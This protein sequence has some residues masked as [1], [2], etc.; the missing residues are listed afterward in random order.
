MALTRLQNI[1]SSVEGRIIYV[2]PD[3][4]DSTDAIDNKG[5]SPLRPFK[6]I[7]RAVLEVARY[8]YVSAGNADDKFDQ[9]TIML[10]PGDH[11]VDNRPGSYA[12]AI[13]GN[14]NYVG[15]LSAVPFSAGPVSGQYGWSD[16]T[17]QYADLYKI[18]NS[19]RG[20]L[21]IP[22][23]VS[24]VGM[25]LRKTK[26]RPKFVP[27][28][29]TND[30]TGTTTISFTASDTNRNELTI[31]GVSNG[32]DGVNNINDVIIGSIFKKGVAGY[33]ISNTFTAGA[34]TQ[35]DPATGELILNIGSLHG[36][37][38]DNSI[39]IADNSLAFTCLSDGGNSIVTYPRNTD[40][41]SDTTISIQSVDDAG[42]TITVNVG[43]SSETSAHTFVPGSSGSGNIT[44]V[45][46]GLKI[47]EGTVITGISTQTGSSSIAVEISKPHNYLLTD[48]GNGTNIG[49]GIVI[50]LP[51][52]DDNSRT[53]LFRITGGCYFWQFSIFDG[54]P[55]G[56]YKSTTV[57]P[58]PTWSLVDDLQFSHTKLTVFEYASLHDLKTFYRKVSDVISVISSEKIEAKIQENRIVGAL[59]D[60]VSV[61]KV[62]RNNSIVTITLSQE[63]EI[64][65]GNFVAVRGA[66]SA[67]NNAN[68]YY[69]GQRQVTTVNSGSEFTYTLPSSSVT[70]LDTLEAS[71]PGDSDTS[72]NGMQVEY[73]S[74][75][76][77]VQVEIDTVE[78][79]SPYIFNVSLRS[80]YGICGM[81]ADGSRATGFRSM[82]VAQ[83]TG[84]S[85][86]KDDSAFLKYNGTTFVTQSG[87]DSLHT[88]AEA[89]YNPKQRS[90]H[91]KASNRAVIQAVSVFAVGYADHFI[92][93]DGGD[94][95]ITNSNSNFGM[96]SMRSIGFSDQAF[97]KDA[98][99]KITHIIP[100]RNVESTLSN[101]YYESIDT[102]KTQAYGVAN[103][104][105]RIYLS[106]RDDFL[107]I[108]SGG[109]NFTSGNVTVK[110]STGQNRTIILSATNGVVTSATFSGGYGTF[111]PGDIVTIPTNAVDGVGLDCVLTIGNGLLRKVGKFTV[112][113][114]VLDKDG[115]TIK[116]N[117]YVPLYETSS[118]TAT[119]ERYAEITPS[120]GNVF[121]YDSTNPQ[122]NTAGGWYI[123]V[124]SSTN[125]IYTAINGNT[126]YGLNKI[127]VTPTSYIKRIV[128]ERVDDDKIY[129]LRYVTQSVSGSPTDPSP[130]FPQRGYVLQVKRGQ[131]I[132]GRGDRFT[133][134]ANLLLL[135]KYFLAHEAVARWINDNVGN[136]ELN[137]ASERLSCID[138]LV[139]IIEA[140]AYNLRYG[141]ND[142]VF[143]AANNYITGTGAGAN[144]I[145]GERDETVNI[146]D[147]YLKQL[148][149]YVIN[150]GVTGSPVNTPSIGSIENN[151]TS[152]NNSNNYGLPNVINPQTIS[153]EEQLINVFGG[154]TNVRDAAFT[155]V[156]I[157][158]QALGSDTTP[159]N[160]NSIT[161]TTPADEDIKYNRISGHDYNDVY[162]VY[163]VEEV[164]PFKK[165]TTTIPEV[166]GVYYL[167]V[168]KGS[169]PVSTNVLP[170][171]T[172]KLSQNIDNIYPEIDI[173][174]IINDPII[175]DSIADPI[176][177]G[178]VNTTNG[179]DNNDQSL[180]NSFSITKE[181]LSYFFDEYLNNEL[182]WDW[183]GKLSAS[184]SVDHSYIVNGNSEA[185]DLISTN[186]QTGIGT[187]EVRKIPINPRR[188]TDAIEVELRRP[189]TIRSGNHT[190]EYVGFGPGNYSTAFPIKQNKVLTNAEVKYSQSLKEQGGIAFYSGLNSQGDLYIGNTVINAVTGKTT[191]NEISELNSLTLKDNLTVIGGS[192]NTITSTFQGP[193]TFLKD[194]TFDSED[195]FF[196][197][198]KIRNPDGIV[199]KIINRDSVDAL[200]SN[201]L[202][203]TVLN[204]NPLNG[205]NR[206]WIYTEDNEW[207]EQGIIGVEKIHSYKDGSNY[208]LNIGS[209]IGIANIN[210]NYDLDVTTNQR[211]GTNLDIGVGLTGSQ[212]GI[213]VSKQS[214]LH[215]SQTWS[216]STL[217]YRPLEI[218]IAGA[219]VGAPESRI[220][221]AKVGGN[222][223]FNVDKVGNVNIPV[224][225][226]YGLSK[227]AF[228]TTIL[229]KSVANTTNNQDTITTLGAGSQL[230]IDVAVY[231]GSTQV[232]GSNGVITR[233][234][235]HRMTN[236]LVD[237]LY[238]GASVDTPHVSGSA[239]DADVGGIGNL[240]DFNTRSMIVYVNGVIQ[241][242]YFDYHFDGTYLYFNG[243]IAVDGRIDIRCLAN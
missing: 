71:S 220:I 42:G 132:L 51:Y 78:S 131:D 186:I 237:F 223:V 198:I 22:R 139:N 218:D 191:S 210:T 207:R 238:Y 128:D 15:A 104:S 30:V 105:S 25:D 195:N 7:A 107:A 167:T 79:A 151:N 66:V 20:G 16:T 163:E 221:D 138:D 133:D 35:Y 43:T 1:I 41:A 69:I 122:T 201:I 47:Q 83:Y 64:T 29:G 205:G 240:A 161:S 147:N 108:T 176:T 202:G 103:S 99:G 145:Q 65:A 95:S 60:Q 180:N 232:S 101:S 110:D 46:T 121:D 38:T 230:T 21:I 144:G 117:I 225:A 194:T 19:V 18:T 214:R 85:L 77:D 28:G 97:K 111:Q 209:D 146:L 3:D 141:G 127:E 154:C 203:D 119:S 185:H 229:I 140:V 17:R 174:N 196:S 125:Q 55:S 91:V 165:A 173:N 184:S 241:Q 228:S 170:G 187:G 10:Y 11:I 150:N 112:G 50:D 5:N 189:S 84:I 9:F 148:M 89:I 124:D 70:Q 123:N 152:G 179:L 166:P 37:T 102:L 226:S 183:S 82:V 162:Y 36:L 92:A 137:L 40:P 212:P 134:G 90:Y 227:K 204:T 164:T 130:S 52:E 23:G 216:G 197:A 233:S 200:T 32:P 208:T 14:S 75:S 217:E 242:P 159:G 44:A 13:D 61:T 193:V 98:L 120:L 213:S 12:Y 135:N 68:A 94:M 27:N 234:F 155:L 34:G 235:G 59:A 172:F 168:L 58:E 109:S 169:I 33:S 231:Q 57:K 114:R 129:R 126:K 100:P 48:V 142:Q 181:S 211:I 182:E 45:N 149:T 136:S 158:V 53:A 8:S 113:S 93:E 160:L 236:Q 96:N 222:S 175:A 178:V 156:D 143:S 215:I 206:G 177:I 192:G 6:T 56:V 188:P 26:I 224:G 49:A 62:T 73:A 171:N 39:R 81:H 24:L 243:S 115:S 190:F 199:T 88:D 239:R 106:G 54:D 118:A 31:T 2:N 153:S 116:D 219:P 63:L 72:T 76:A 80:T 4:F 86:Q 74:P 157:I 67:D 87:N